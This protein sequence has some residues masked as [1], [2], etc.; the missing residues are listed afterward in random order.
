MFFLNIINPAFTSQVLWIHMLVVAPIG[1]MF[2]LDM[3]SPGIMNRK[4]R[5]VQEPI[6]NTKM[7]VRLFIAGLFMA[8]MGCS[9]PIFHFPA[10]PA[11]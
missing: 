6:I 2:G 9:T 4:P 5:N 10:P 3:A 1:A 8:A 7:Y 11:E